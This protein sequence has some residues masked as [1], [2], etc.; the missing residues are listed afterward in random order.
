M[1][2][3][4][5]T[6]PVDYFLL[7]NRRSPGIA[8]V[9]NAQSLLRW[10]ERRGYALSGS[11]VVYR[12]IGLA[13][14]II[15]LRLLTDAHFVAWH[16]WRVLVQRPPVGERGRLAKDIWHPI[17]EDLDITKVVVEKVLQPKQVADGEWNID[18]AF[19]EFRL[20]IPTLE[21]GESS[22]ENEN[23]PASL[24]IVN[25]S[26]IVENNGDGNILDALSP[27]GGL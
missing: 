7:Q 6:D 10:D 9:K 22:E 11:R 16:E 15:T 13:R 20:P 1:T 18:I 26:E 3:N 5:I 25:L 23:D 14:P 19:I 4:P 8:V 21:T 24:T 2:F 27:L 17:L 12:G